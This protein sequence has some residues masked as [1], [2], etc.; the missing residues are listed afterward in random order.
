MADMFSTKSKVLAWI[1]LVGVLAGMLELASYVV[2]KWRDGDVVLENYAGTISAAESYF[3]SREFG[4]LVP[5]PGKN[6]VTVKLPEYVDNFRTDDTLG[7]GLGFF[8]DGIDSGRELY[9]VAIGDSFT[10]GVGSIDNLKYGWVELVEREL[11]WLDLL[12]LGNSGTGQDQQFNFY[13]K[14]ASLI[15]H[16]L[17]V[18]NFFAGGD[19][20]DNLERDDVNQMLTELP[21][22][23]DGTKLV[24]GFLLNTVYRPAEEFL[25]NSWIPSRLVWL[26]DKSRRND[27]P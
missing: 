8:D 17:V 3:F 7:K 11:N 23:Q 6:I 25:I 9:A 26:V 12:N 14:I 1:L 13:D 19:F 22:D 10:R 27:F 18:V 20:N 15:D 24:R 21:L 5:R 2:W 16:Q 4:I